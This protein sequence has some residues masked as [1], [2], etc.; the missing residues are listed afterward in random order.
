MV[1]YYT[2]QEYEEARNTIQGRS[3]YR[4]RIG[5]ILGSG[6]NPL[7]EAVKDAD[8]ISYADIPHFP[9]PT[10]EGHA[11][12][13][14]L[15]RL[16]G[17][18][19]AIMQGRVHFYEGYPI[20][21]V[22][23]PVRVMQ[24]L[25]VKTLIVTNAAGGLNP[26]FQAGELML[27]ADHLNIIGM[28]GNNPL[29]GPNDESFGPR[30]PDMSQAYDPELRGIAR[31]VARE[32]EIPLHEGVY[33]ALSGPSFETPAEIRFLR[34]IGAD[35]VGMSTVPEVIVARHG[36]IRVL[37]ISGISNVLVAE[38]SPGHETTH[39]EVLAA[40]RE[41]VPRLTKLICSVLDRLAG[42]A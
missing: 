27:I 40:G 15:G 42:G 6:L 35:A 10:V 8:R 34:T 38:A 14:V 39:E 30:F 28:S 26:E 2:R 36:G 41:I 11:G 33:A 23:F 37:G 16:Q 19:V 21:Q 3:S 13:L 20:Q 18:D 24:V 12:Q 1:K 25:G 4:P 22:V 9:R 32:G 17:A 5:M 31:E 7:A 29:F